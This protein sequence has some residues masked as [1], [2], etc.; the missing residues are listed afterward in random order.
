MGYNNAMSDEVQFDTDTQNNMMRRQGPVAGFGQ[1]VAEGSGMA[2][3]LMRHG[4]AKS[5]RSAQ[6]VM[7]GI[8]VV[9]IIAI[10]VV[11]KFFL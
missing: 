7:A 10:F 6:F 8:V 2:G 11:I 1:P 9:D 4:L 5:P 3:W